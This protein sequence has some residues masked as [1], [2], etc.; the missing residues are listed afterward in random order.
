MIKSENVSDTTIQAWFLSGQGESF[1]GARKKYE[2]ICGPAES[3]VVRETIPPT[4][5]P[6][7]K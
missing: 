6:H 1:R 4:A 7:K 5:R 3:S 2:E